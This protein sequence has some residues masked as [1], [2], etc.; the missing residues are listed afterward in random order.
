[1]IDKIA[2]EDHKAPETDDNMKEWILKA[3]QT[4]EV[5]RSLF[6]IHNSFYTSHK[7]NARRSFQDDEEVHIN[8]QHAQARLELLILQKE[9]SECSKKRDGDK[10]DKL[11]KNIAEKKQ[12]IQQFE[13]D[14]DYDKREAESVFVDKKRKWDEESRERFKAEQ[15]ARKSEQELKVETNSIGSDPANEDNEDGLIGLFGDQAE[16]DTSST[17]FVSKNLNIIDVSPRN[18]F[19]QKWSGLYPKK[20]L[21]E[22]CR[23]ID[24]QSTQ[25]YAVTSP[26][27]NLFHASVKI[28]MKKTETLFSMEDNS[29]V[30]SKAD[31]Q[32]YVAVSQ[33]NPL[34]CQIHYIQYSD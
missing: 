25:T 30:S 32:E 8:E 20:M 16:D 14:W 31:A 27:T 11:K 28:R 21:N 24:T 18:S 2:K 17:T 10:I 4:Y 26:A 29:V 3:A 33:K 6:N 12:I 34:F 23:S 7:P 22:H 9:V 19:N 15:I 5:Y 13:S 1:M